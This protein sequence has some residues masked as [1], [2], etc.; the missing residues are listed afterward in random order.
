[1]AIKKITFSQNYKHYFIK[2]FWQISI[3]F[4]SKLGELD[5]DSNPNKRLKH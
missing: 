3:K 5:V 4:S 1:M 2:N